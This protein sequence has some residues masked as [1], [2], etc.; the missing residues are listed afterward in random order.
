MLHSMN[1]ASRMVV[2]NEQLA[3]RTLNIVD[4]LLCHVIWPFCLCV[5]GLCH[6]AGTHR[7][8]NLIKAEDKRIRQVFTRWFVC[9]SQLTNRHSIIKWTDFILR[10]LSWSRLRFWKFIIRW[11]PC[12]CAKRAINAI[13][14][15]NINYEYLCAQN[16]DSVLFVPERIRF[17]TVDLASQPIA[18]ISFT[19]HFFLSLSLAVRVHPR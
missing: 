18:V 4:R 13:E 16:S 9:N 7:P 14:Q 8:S 5:C 3:F 2:S 15:Q 12:V 10:S 6:T 19:S 17:F 1:E 11:F